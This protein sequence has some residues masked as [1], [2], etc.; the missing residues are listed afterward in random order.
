MIQEEK[1]VKELLGRFAYWL[2]QIKIT[3]G[4]YLF[5]ANKFGEPL[6]L[7]LLNLLYN[8]ELKDLNEEKANAPGI[9]LADKKNGIAFQIS[10]RTD[11]DKVTSTLQKAVDH[12]FAADY[13]N[14]IRFLVLSSDGKF[15]FARK[16][17]TSILATFDE[18][19]D[20][21]YPEDVGKQIKHIYETDE[22][23]F[24]QVKDLLQKEVPY[25]ETPQP[26]TQTDTTAILKLLQQQLEQASGVKAPALTIEALYEADLSLPLLSLASQR[27]ATVETFLNSLKVHS[28]V[29]IW[30]SVDT[31]KSALTYLIAKHYEPAAFWL[32]L[33]DQDASTLVSKS[34]SLLASYLDVPLQKAWKE[35]LATIAK[36]LPPKSILVINDV[37]SLAGVNKTKQ[38]FLHFCQLL[39]QSG[40]K[41]LLTSNYAPYPEL[42]SALAEKISAVPV[43]F[44]SDEETADV[45]RFYGATED[46]VTE[47]KKLVAVMTDGHAFL[48]HTAT[49]YLKDNGWNITDDVF[50]GLFKNKY[51]DAYTAEVYAKILSS[52]Q[53][54][55]TRTLLYRTAVVIGYFADDEISVVGSV[56]PAVKHIHQRAQALKGIWLQE[57]ETG[58]FQLSPLLKQLGDNLPNDLQQAINE[59][60][61]D[62]ITSKPMLSQI[63]TYNA[64]LYYQRGKAYVKLSWV[65]VRVLEFSLSNPE[66]FFNWGFQWFWYHVPFPKDFPSVFKAMIRVFHVQLASD[67]GED[68]TFLVNDLESILEKEDVGLLSK[69]YA[70]LM[71]SHIFLK[72][73]PVKAFRY[74]LLARVHW[75]E[76][77]EAMPESG[78]EEIRF[79]DF[80]WTSFYSL[81]KREDFEEWFALLETLDEIPNQGQLDSV[82]SYMLA[83]H[84]LVHLTVLPDEA[85]PQ[86]AIDTLQAIYLLAVEVD[87]PLMA[88]Y[89]LKYLI[90]V[91]GIYTKHLDDAQN[92]L[93][94]NE[95]LISSKPIYVFLVKEEY[96]RQLYYAGRNK[97]ALAILSEV[98]D[99]VVEKPFL[100]GVEG[101]RV[102]AQLTGET[103]S[104]AA[105]LYIQKALHKVEN[106]PFFPEVGRLKLLG[107]AAVSLWL[108]KKCKEAVY[109]LEDAYERLLKIFQETEEHQ[110]LLIRLAHVANYLRGEMVHGQPPQKTADGGEYTVPVRGLFFWDDKKLQESGFYFEE[111]KFIGSTI[112]DDIFEFLGD[113]KTARKWALLGIE[114]SLSLPESKYFPVLYKSIQYLV[115]DRQFTKAVNLF[116]Y[117]DEKLSNIRRLNAEGKDIGDFAQIQHLLAL[118]KKDSFIFVQV[119]I[120]TTITV[121]H[122]IITNRITED[123]Y[124]ALIEKLFNTWHPLVRQPDKL[125]FLHSIFE[126]ILINRISIANLEALLDSYT[127]LDKAPMASV[128]Y[129]LQS[130]FANVKEAVRLQLPIAIQ[131]DLYQQLASA[132]YRFEIVPF[133]KTFWIGKFNVYRNQV[134]SWEFW[135]SRSLPHI[136]NAALDRSIKSIFEVLVLHT[137]VPVTSAIE[138]WMFD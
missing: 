46:F 61:A 48:I 1:E 81:R 33:R 18:K 41:L 133:L 7:K 121:A 54:D 88:V 58:R 55:E 35:N 32:D 68:I 20:I 4:A 26:T 138:K 123:E 111:R 106:D 51:G 16:K 37:P 87:L 76:L 73:D 98:I 10:S 86:E 29:W 24:R 85:N 82:E 93:H 135:Q 114:L 63:E 57:G 119:I 84:S 8:L 30:G 49:L 94:Q 129:I 9:D 50:T 103:D 25:P 134:R 96:G 107:E 130:V 42:K 132:L 14:G 65:L 97:E 31:G 67:R 113:Y 72:R 52:T 70:E 77:Q 127:G 11:N 40:T 89:A 108:L 56:N 79:D 118:N 105:D 17:P 137:E 110:A 112:F 53:D 128:A 126:N 15:T 80:F 78:Q 115:M 75:K 45:L 74:Y 101:L 91:H 5:D 71:I 43:P 62:A 69:G 23:R 59:A 12:K 2:L 102:F 21:V 117:L 60:L 131:L 44:F 66:V 83:A 100:D 92:L 28:A 116:Q 3:N 136:Q 13:P 124:S 125:Q 120:P 122:D 104:K 95:A 38:E 90:A 34:V 39:A 64:L 22:V 99:T 47:S 6:S 19:R 109:Y 36:K 27:T